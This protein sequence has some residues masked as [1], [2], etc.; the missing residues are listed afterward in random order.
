M[1]LLHTYLLLGFRALRRDKVASLINVV[2]LSAAVACAIALLLLLQEINTLDD[3]HANGDRI[4]LVGHTTAGEEGT[5]RWGTAPAPLGPA[6]AAD[7]PAVARAVRV[8]RRPVT[9]QAGASSFHETLTF[10]DPGFFE[11]FTFPLQHGSVAL[12]AD[13]RAVILSAEMATKHFGTDDAVGQTL[14]VTFDPSGSSGGAA[15]VLT[16]GGVAAPFPPRAG[17]RFDLLVGYD[18][19]GVVGLADPERWSTFTDA[20]FLL[21]RRADAAPAVAEG[22]GR[23]VGVQRAAGPDEDRAVASFFLDSV[24]H[25]DWWTAWQ[26]EDRALQAP[27]LWESLMFG[28]IALLILLVACFNYVT[29]S[30]GSVAYRLREIGVRK[31]IGAGRGELV[32]QFLAE[33]LVLCSLSVL[34]GI[35]LAWAVTVPFLNGLLHRPNPLDLADAWGFWPVLAGLPVFLGLAAGS[36]PALYV[37]SFQPTAILRGRA[38]PAEKR[39]LMRVLTVV[40]FVLALVTLCLALFTASLDDKLLGGDWGYAP[41]GLL[42]VATGS[43][44]H[45]AWLRREAEALGVREMAGAAQPIGSAPTPVVVRVGQEEHEAARYAV[46]PDY[47][48][49]LGLGTAAGRAFGT[50]FSADSASSVVVNE[51]FARQQGW[52]DP[53]GERVHLDG[54]PLAVVGVVEDF[55][56]APTAGT[57]R[58][59][60]LTLASPA[61]YRSLTL[62]AGAGIVDALDAALRT[63]WAA[64]FPA[65]AFVSYPQTEA[66]ARES[67]G[68]VSRFITSLA[69]FALLISCMGLFGL[70]AQRAAGRRREVGVRKAMGAS[71]GQIVL[72]VNRG[73]LAMLG[74]ATLI[75]TPLCYLGLRAVLAVA[76]VEVA[77]GAGPFVLSNAVVFILAACTLAWQTAALV[78]VR[79]AEVLR[80]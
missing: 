40:Q 47:L 72:L 71:A 74:V 10:A 50:A 73:F 34:G 16:V 70:A 60:V 77:L 38:R 2:G 5:R 66:F 33:G 79:P 53:I 42:V 54:R 12:L 36:Y 59:A 18:K 56:L 24:Q 29:I 17:F 1:S 4:F 57:A 44:D 32:R 61:E 27:L 23:Y 6:A 58:P 41:D 31:S 26:I 45:Y 39:V 19:L 21:L 13:P 25:P 35:G 80:S 8:A 3:F 55:L 63:R 51:T 28:V 46:G 30:L 64:E 22:L 68:G 75:A 7:L 67:F 49:T 76:P 52:A 9:V 43:P 78:Q 15:E 69:L 11:L 14:A 37:S 65:V 20:T 48:A 62:R